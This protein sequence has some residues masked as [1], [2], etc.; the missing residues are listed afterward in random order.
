MTVA[1]ITE[2]QLGLA[3]TAARL[4]DLLDDDAS[5]GT[6]AAAVAEVIAQASDFVQEYATQAGVTLAAATL[7]ASMRRR[8]CIVAVYY[9]AV[10][11]PQYRD[12]QGHAPYYQ[13]FLQVVAELKAWV[14]GQAG[15]STDTLPSTEGSVAIT[16]TSRR[17]Q[18][19]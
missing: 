8:V 18:T 5:G 16:T 19:R 10:R 11:R 6:D 2:A 9:A 15:L 1:L 13:E 14:A 12:A 17:W 7:T 4:V 3:L